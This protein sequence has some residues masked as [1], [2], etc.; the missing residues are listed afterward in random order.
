MSVEIFMM[1][2]LLISALTGLA[3]EALKKLLTEYKKTYHS[4]MLA[5]CVALAVSVMVGAAYIIM[6]SAVWNAKMAVC[7]IAL[8]LLSWL[9]AMVGYDKVIQTITQLKKEG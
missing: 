5:G 1:G 3:T 4:N 9:C 8:M 2:L 7:L 6:T